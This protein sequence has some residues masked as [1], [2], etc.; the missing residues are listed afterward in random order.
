PDRNGLNRIYGESS[1]PATLF[2]SCARGDDEPIVAR[3]HA[4]LAA[5]GF[6]VWWDCK[7][8]V[9]CYISLFS[10]DSSPSTATSPMDAAFPV[11]STRPAKSGCTGKN[12]TNPTN[13]RHHTS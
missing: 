10:V 7:D 1:M 3:L 8:N 6:D 11:Y 4:D 13:Q 9:G 12:V 5:R 2:L